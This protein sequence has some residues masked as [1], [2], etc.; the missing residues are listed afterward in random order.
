MKWAPE[1]T[2]PSEDLSCRSFM[3]HRCLLSAVHAEPPSGN[4]EGVEL[5]QSL[6]ESL[7]RWTQ[8]AHGNCQCVVDKG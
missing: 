5:Y 3:E 4:V 6:T 7:Q 1:N 8:D 2:W